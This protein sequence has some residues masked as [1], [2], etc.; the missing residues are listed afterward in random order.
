MPLPDNRFFITAI[1]STFFHYLRHFDTLHLGFIAADAA[2]SSCINSYASHFHSGRRHVSSFFHF[3]I[4]SA[5]N[6]GC[7]PAA[8]IALIVDIFI[9]PH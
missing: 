1:F 6:A 3:T 9:T 5:A 8:D 2:L 7:R 4:S